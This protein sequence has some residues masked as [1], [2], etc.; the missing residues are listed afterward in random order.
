MTGNLF[1]QTR[2]RAAGLEHVLD[3]FAACEPETEVDRRPRRA[4]Q[5]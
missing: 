5:T 4:G 3:E 1:V 2:I